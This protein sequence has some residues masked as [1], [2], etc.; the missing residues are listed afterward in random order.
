MSRY[1]LCT[2]VFD[3]RPRPSAIRSRPPQTTTLVPNRL[4]RRTE[5]GAN[6]SSTRAMGAIPKPVFSGLKPRQNCRYWVMR[7]NMPSR[8]NSARASEAMAAL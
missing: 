6:T 7:K 8:A 5:S 1:V 4:T 2:D 3:S